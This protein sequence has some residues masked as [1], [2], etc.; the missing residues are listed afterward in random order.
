MLEVVGD[1]P[2]VARVHCEMGWTALAAS[3][4]RAAAE[5]FRRAVHAYEG[6]GS[7]RGTARRCSVWRRSRP[8]KTAPSRPSR[9][10][11]RPRLSWRARA[12]WWRTRWPPTWPNG[13]RRSSRRSRRARWTA[14]R[15][16]SRRADGSGRS[17][18][19]RGSIRDRHD[20][21]ALPHHRSSRRRRDGGGVAG[22]RYQARPRGRAQGPAGSIRQRPRQIGQIRTR[23]QSARRA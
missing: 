21:R 11:P 17:G 15:G 8:P 3:D 10:L 12:P 13:S 18:N 19:G 2:E 5:S 9:S 22:D 1:H 14:A 6:V 16:R 20:P 4:P 23:S 7:A